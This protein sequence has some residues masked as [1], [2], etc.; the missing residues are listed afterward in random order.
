MKTEILKDELWYP[1]VSAYG[2]DMPY[3]E[4]FYGR[5]RLRNNLTVNQMTPLLLSSHGRLLYRAAGFDAVFNRGTIETSEGAE[6]VWSGRTLRQ[7]YRYAAAHYFAGGRIQIADRLIERPIYN[8]WM[9]APFQVTQDKMLAYAQAILDLGLPAGTI[10]IDDKW[11][12]AYGTWEFDR[13]KFPQPQAMME[14]LHALGFAVMLLVCPYVS[15]DAPGY[16]SCRRQDLLLMQEKEVYRLKWWNETSACLDLCKPRAMNYIRRS[17]AALAVL[18]ADGFKMD[19]GDSWY[20]RPEHEPDRQ[21]FLWAELA[22]EYPFN[23]IRADFNTAGRSIFERLSDKRHSWGEEGIGA[24]IPDALALGLGGHPFF[25]PDMIGGGEVKDLQDGCK[26]RSDIFLAHCQAALLMP[27]M[28]F[29]VLPSQVP[30][31]C[32]ELHSLLRQR[33]EYLPYIMELFGQCSDSKEPMVRLLEYEFPQAG[34][35][36]QLDSF[37]LGDRYLV[38][39]VTKENEREKEITLPPGSWLLNGERLSGGR[40]VTLPLTLER[41][42]V[43]RREYEKE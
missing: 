28:Q 32:E 10:I 12:V 19:G 40:T 20:Y 14:Q 3:D 39:P 9:Y 41:L 22:S 8:T 21:S 42:T 23:E 6:L 18:G 36:R 27:S 4:N 17:L 11:S 16:D 38:V 30:N 5:V 13:Q 2:S 35:G 37:M 24:L 25:A 34:F 26:L 15:F 7:A 33:E 29:S 43:L 31:V 1:A